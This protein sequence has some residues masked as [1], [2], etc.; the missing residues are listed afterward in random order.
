MHDPCARG[1]CLQ[2][3]T[4][5]KHLTEGT[6]VE[7][8]KY[9]SKVKSEIFFTTLECQRGVSHAYPLCEED[10]GAFI[11]VR[12]LL[13]SLQSKSSPCRTSLILAKRVFFLWPKSFSCRVSL[14]LVGPILSLQSK[15]S[16]CRASFQKSETW[17]ASLGP[18]SVRGS[19]QR[20]GLAF[21]W[22]MDMGLLGSPSLISYFI[23]FNSFW[24]VLLVDVSIKLV[25][26]H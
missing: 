25:K 4:T 9:P 20:M 10:V 21:Y 24:L 2:K 6:G 13:L 5:Q 11:V 18:R 12:P 15:S 14:L 1:R 26:S 23:L 19:T 7:P 22:P 3:I 16:S 17:W 8:A